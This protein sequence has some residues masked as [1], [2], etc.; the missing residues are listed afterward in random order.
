MPKLLS[1]VAALIDDGDGRL[2]LV[3]KR[4]T[5]AFML[6]GG[7]RDG[8]EAPFDTLARELSEELGFSP[9]ESEVRYLGA[10]SAQAANEPDHRVD[11]RIFHIRAA[12]RSFTVGAELAEGRWVTIDEAMRL[13][14][15]PLARDHVLPLARKAGG[16]LF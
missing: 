13:P 5:A 3:R 16:P 11:A 9:S 1:I 8:E 4:G 14:L 7:K 6:A 15:A 2:F 10:F 12:G